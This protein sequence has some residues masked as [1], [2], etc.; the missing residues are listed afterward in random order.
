MVSQPSEAMQRLVERLR[1]IQLEENEKMLEEKKAE[2][3]SREAKMI[4][5]DDESDSW[6]KKG[7]MSTEARL[8]RR[9]HKISK[10]AESNAQ[11]VLHRRQK[12]RQFLMEAYQLASSGRSRIQVRQ[13]LEKRGLIRNMTEFY[14]YLNKFRMKIPQFS[15]VKEAFDNT[16]QCSNAGAYKEILFLFYEQSQNSRGLDPQR[17]FAM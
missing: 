14:V 7:L 17:S 16:I 1:Q 11:P 4:D 10:Q 15:T 9:S 12:V 13:E 6:K 8:A 3:I 2:E 5:E